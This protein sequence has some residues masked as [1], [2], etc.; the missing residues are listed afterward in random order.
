M[1]PFAT[2]FLQLN[3]RAVALERDVRAR[4]NNPAITLLGNA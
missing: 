2:P 4:G 1:Q 3:D